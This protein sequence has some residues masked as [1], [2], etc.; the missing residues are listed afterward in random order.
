MSLR[1]D[2]CMMCRELGAKNPFMLMGIAC[3]IFMHYTVD[4]LCVFV[5]TWDQWWGKENGFI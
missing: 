4:F 2:F 3:L 5:S 1:V